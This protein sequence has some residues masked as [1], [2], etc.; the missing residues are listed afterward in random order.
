MPKKIDLTHKIFQDLFVMREATK[1]EKNFKPGAWWV[2]K[3]SCGNVVIKD[4]QG[5]RKGYTTSCGCK[6]LQKLKNRPPKKFIDESNKKYGRLTV[7]ERD[8]NE[9]YKKAHCTYW[10]CKCQC[11]NQVTVARDSLISGKTKSCGCFR[12]ENSSKFLTNISK[13]NFINEIGNRYGKLLV[14]QKVENNTARQGALWLCQCDC[15]KT[16]LAIGEDLRQ[17]KVI[18]CGCLRQSKG[19][20]FIQQLLIKNQIIYTKEY[21]QKINN[22]NL[23][24]DFAIIQNQKI[25]YFIEFDGKQ[26]FESV[27]YFGGQQNFIQIQKNDKIKNDWCK[28]NN[29]PLIRIPFSHLKNLTITDLLLNTSNFIIC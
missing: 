1:E 28:K 25:Q 22:K 20:F 18:S 6:T 23:R 29:I 4:G 24:F 10:K 7:I 21:T 8:Y 13:N 27:K 3:C 9:K 2:C 11:G 16:K 17:G 19:E 5:L 15:G 26:H 12:K 14:I